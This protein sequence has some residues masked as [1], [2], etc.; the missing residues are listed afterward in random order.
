MSNQDNNSNNGNP[1]PNFALEASATLI[2]FIF[3]P[4]LL[5]LVLWI[6]LQRLAGTEAA[7][8]VGLI[9]QAVCLFAFRENV[10]GFLKR[11][12]GGTRK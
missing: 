5:M 8:A 12:F 7:I 4:A 6:P 11:K 1:G 9:L 3:I 2:T 10:A